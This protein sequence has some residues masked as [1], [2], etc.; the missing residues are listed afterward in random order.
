[1]LLEVVSFVR[2]IRNDLI[3]VGQAHL[4]DFPHRGIGL[5]RRAGHDL[6]ADATP[7]RRVLQ[8][9][10]LGLVADFATSFTNQ[11]INCRHFTVK[12]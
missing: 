8:S 5:L 11:L 3:A 10:G 12:F 1:M 9:R 2:N 4:G 6:N 7:K